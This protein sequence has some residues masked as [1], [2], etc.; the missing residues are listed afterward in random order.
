MIKEGNY[1]SALNFVEIS[2]SKINKDEEEEIRL[3]KV[4]IYVLKEDYELAR[5]ELKDLR[6]LYPKGLSI[7]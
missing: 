1:D 6:Q 4:K 3:V 7:L 2:L 5:K